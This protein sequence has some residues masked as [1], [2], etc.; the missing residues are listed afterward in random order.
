MGKARQAAKT[1]ME[2]LKL[3][4]MTCLELI[5]EAAKM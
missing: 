2:K 4:D 3:K 1:E 5:K